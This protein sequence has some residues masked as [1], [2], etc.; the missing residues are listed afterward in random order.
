MNMKLPPAWRLPLACLLVIELA[1]LLLYSR[2]GLAMVEIW[3]RSGT[4]AHAWVV[5]PISLWLIW[6]QRDELLARLPRFMPWM[7]LPMLLL[8]AAWLMGDLVAVNAVTQLS[9]VAMVVCAVP[10]CLGWQATRVIVF[11][12]LF[13][14]FCVPIGEFMLPTMMEWTADFTVSALQFSGVPV[15]RE[16][17]SFVIPSG[18]WSVIE[19]CSGVRYLIASTMVG[20]LFAYLNYS[21]MKKRVI[22]IV[23]SMVLPVIANWLRAYMIVML[24]HLSNNAIATGVDHLIYG[25]VFFGIVMLV[26]FLVGMRWADPLPQQNAA[27]APAL[28]AGGA[29][30]AR[31][32]VLTV[33]AL[34]LLAAPV[35]AM[36]RITGQGNANPVVLSAPD[37]EAKGW[38]R[39]SQ[40]FPGFKPRF[41][42]PRA[43]VEALYDRNGG[44][45]V[46]VYLGY[47]R[48]QDYQSKL[49]S[50]SNVLTAVDDKTWR[51]N[52]QGTFDVPLGDSSMKVRT[53]EL[54]SVGFAG[55]TQV[56][57]L[58]AWE[59]Y[60][61]NGHWTR[62][63]VTAKLYGA[64]ARL[65][66]RGDDGAVLV[67][68]G[69]RGEPTADAMTAFLRENLVLFEQRLQATKASADTGARS[70]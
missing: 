65:L 9:L 15:Y 22:F 58:Q 37:V 1:I 31:N 41:E 17:L 27:P 19:A 43:E 32:G 10:L 14:F 63:D 44:P 50:S 18:S 42:A 57:R 6:R 52:K 47:Y 39:T 69:D 7:L 64:W 24:G 51:I 33:V 5:P 8:G 55:G 23:V 3:D 26:L 66:G 36:E 60:W 28:A 59:I 45:V 48:N 30:F 56:Q 34:V 35:F 49:I 46:G 20:T 4:F 61:V 40:Q 62:S 29:S 67:L 68:Y 12:L 21:S 25:W 38:Q 16:G 2:T 53:A 13:L 54:R 11:P 70:Q